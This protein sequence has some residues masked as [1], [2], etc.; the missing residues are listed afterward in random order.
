[1]IEND[2]ISSV[3]NDKGKLWITYT[4]G[5]VVDVPA[6]IGGRET[7]LT[8]PLKGRGSFTMF[9]NQIIDNQY[10]TTYEKLAFAVLRRHVCFETGF[11]FIPTEKIAKAMSCSKNTVTKAIAGLERRNIISVE[12]TFRRNLKKNYYAFRP[13]DEWVLDE[14]PEDAVKSNIVTGAEW[15]CSEEIPF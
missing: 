11:T 15:D 2:N 10:L 7:P 3:S 13:P 1:M 12:R 4:N 5:T 6:T 8:D 9:D 14:L